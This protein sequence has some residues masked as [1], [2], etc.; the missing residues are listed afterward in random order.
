MN[1][2][3]K[4]SPV[5][6]D[7]Y[8]PEIA[9]YV[10]TEKGERRARENGFTERVAGT[11]ACFGYRIIKGGLLAQDWEKKGYIRKRVVAPDQENVDF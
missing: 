5:P 1:I 11:I 4:T 10:Y 2:E 7:M 6:A 3:V 9:P 8:P